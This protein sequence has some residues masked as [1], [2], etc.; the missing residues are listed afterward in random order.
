MSITLNIG[1]DLGSD[2]LK[3]AYAFDLAGK[4]F[5]GKISKES[6]PTEVAVPAIAYYDEQEGKWSFGYDVSREKSSSFTTVVKIKTLL[7]M[8]SHVPAGKGGRKQATEIRARNA[9]FYR[10]GTM[11]PK[12][13][14]P[15]SRKVLSDFNE[16]VSMK[17]TFDGGI[18]PQSV[19]EKFFEYVAELITARIPALEAKVKKDVER[20]KNGRQG[21][22]I[23]RGAL[24]GFKTESLA[25]AGQ[26]K[27]AAI[28]PSG[29]CKEYQQELERLI[30]K[31]FGRAPEKSLSSTKALSIYA[32]HRGMIG[33]NDSA[34]VFDLGETDISVTRANVDGMG[35]LIIDGADGHSAPCEIGGNDVDRAVAE[36]IEEEIKDRE[37]MGTPSYGEEGHIVERGLR[38][39]QYLFMKNIKKAKI[40]LS[41]PQSKEIFPG[42][43]PVNLVRD[44]H[45]QRSLTREAFVACI[46]LGAGKV[47]VAKEI[48]AY[49]INE[50]ALEINKD[51]KKMI[52]S[53]GLAE[54]YGLLDYIKQR[55]HKANADA[56]IITFDE[57]KDGQDGFSIGTYE[58]S[59]YAAA[60]G[61][62]I[63]ALEDIQIK[64]C[65]S[66]TYASWS[67]PQFPTEAEQVLHGHKMLAMI[68]GKGQVLRSDGL[69]VFTFPCR[70]GLKEGEVKCTEGDEIYSLTVRREKVYETA[71]SHPEMRGQTYG[72]GGK[73]YVYVEKSGTT[74]SESEKKWRSNLEKYL[75]LRVVSGGRDSRIFYYH[76]GIRVSLINTFIYYREGV[77]IDADG[78]ATPIIL[79]NKV[80]N[81]G[82]MARVH[83][84]LDEDRDIWTKNETVVPADE[85]E[86]RFEGMEEFD[87]MSE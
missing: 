13:Y 60:V 23:L 62:A 56:E 40:L 15:V 57:E 61:A 65:L 1:L 37:T 14:F 72:G 3:A 48:A 54:T 73:R 7:G 76:K 16:M 64:V 25:F 43:V 45:I 63:V 84:L 86:L 24:R 38:E 9:K 39:E 50:L 19:C 41:V 80:D 42:G 47:G 17:M 75:G 82:R 10:E 20:I 21:D 31:A 32:M 55:V 36:H 44:V 58:D 18:S 4:V 5:Y 74:V 79:N 34:L 6:L 68:A 2:T 22:E 49:I 52:I 46:G 26:I 87:A 11:F 77:R 70:L 59:T 30:E 69:N 53:G 8:L 28:Y 67:Y 27:I 33:R 78:V 35:E 83:Y 85:I 12:F 51:V 66:L 29:A 71:R 81:F